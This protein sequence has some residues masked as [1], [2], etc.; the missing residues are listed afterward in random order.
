MCI[1]VKFESLYQENLV[2]IVFIVIF[3]TTLSK[4]IEQYENYYT[5]N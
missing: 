5:N 3:V 4:F 1:N 2:N